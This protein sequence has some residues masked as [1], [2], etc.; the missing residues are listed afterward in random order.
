MYINFH[1]R[2]VPILSSGFKWSVANMA[3]HAIDVIDKV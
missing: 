2:H 3:L 1:F